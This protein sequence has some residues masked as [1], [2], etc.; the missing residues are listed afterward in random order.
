M[1]CGGGEEGNFEA[2]QVPSA[3]LSCSQLQED[4]S[5]GLLDLKQS[6]LAVGLEV[7]ACRMLHIRLTLLIYE[8]G[9]VGKGHYP[10]TH[11]ASF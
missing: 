3:H 4:E 11:L 9:F 6:S 10:D 1:G 5:C 7:L 2:R 8:I